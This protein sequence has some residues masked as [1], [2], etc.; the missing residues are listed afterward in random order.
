MIATR[1]QPFRA[2]ALLS[3]RQGDLVVATR[4]PRS[5]P[6]P[7]DQAVV[8]LGAFDGVHEGHRSLVRA[9][10]DD[11]RL[12]DV[13]CVAMTFDPDPAELLG[14]HRPG[15]RLLDVPDRMAGL[16]EEGVDAVFAVDFTA[17]LAAS[18]PEDFVEQV[19]LRAVRPVAVHVGRNFRF[20]KKASGDVDTLADLGSRLGF[21]ARPH[22]LVESL[23]RPVSATRVRRLL[24]EGSL[25]EA[26]Q[27]LGRCHY[28]RGVVAHGRGEG[29][30]FGFPTA[31]VVCDE[32]CCMPAEGVYACYVVHGSR[33]WPAAANVGA[34]PTFSGPRT[35]FLEANLLGFSGDLYG[36]T[37][38]VAFA[39]WL[40]ASRRFDSLEELERVV[41]GNIGWVGEHLGTHEIA[42]S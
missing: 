30:S 18:S 10:C 21:E 35:A 8:V 3:R 25:D 34:P 4:A 14:S 40:R 2:D 20:G 22:D 1:W 28:V 15:T 39:R 6:R 17:R 27:L 19:L 26:N 32:S 12:R 5:A 36:R 16:L 31:N 29:T 24:L 42:L 13:P 9:A 38:E 41:L 7:Q 23:G 33:A 37:V 11:A